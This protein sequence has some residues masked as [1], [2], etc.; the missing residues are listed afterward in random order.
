MRRPVS[1]RNLGAA[2]AAHDLVRRRLALAATVKSALLVEVVAPGSAAEE[3]AAAVRAR[4]RRAI[5]GAAGDDRQAAAIG[6]AVLIGD[7]AGLDPAL[8]AR[9]Q[10]A[11]TF[12]VIAI[13]GGNIALL[14]VLTAWGV[15]WICGRGRLTLAITAVVLVVYAFVVGSGASVLRATGMAVVGLAART[16]DQRAAAINILALTG[17]AL[18]VADPLLAADTG[19]WLT[20]VATAGLVVG[21]GEADPRRPLVAAT[22][23]ALL[24]TSVWA[25]L[26]LLPIVALAF[27]Q[28]T[29]AGVL[30]SAAAIPGMAM[31]QMAAGVAVVGDLGAGWLIAPAGIALRAG[32]G[33]VIESARVV[34][35]LPF[36]SW[37]VPPPHLAVVVA[38]LRGA[39][40]V[41][42][43]ARAGT[44][45]R[46]GAAAA[47]GA[48]RDAGCWRR[49]SRSRR[50]AWWPGAGPT[51]TVTTLDVG[52]GDAIV[53][54]FPNGATMLVDA[55]GRSSGSFDIGARVVGPALRAR[56][57][58]RL[59]YLVVTHAD[60]DHIG[61]AASVVEEFTPAEVWTG[62][63]VAGDAGTAALRRAVDGVG[64]CLAHGAARRPALDRRGRGRRAAS[65]AARLGAPARPQRRLRGAGGDAGA[66]C[67][68][69]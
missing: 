18:L 20:T 25:E 27:E 54:R 56:G 49:G 37:R 29:L 67:G 52:Q 48:V 31:V 11:G 13:S 59:D 57:I 4:A 32:A 12:H 2:D 40:R 69:C 21:L 47:G 28:V 30:L 43:G 6:T 22:G 16:L 64:D 34:E 55:G 42:V 66:A 35:W 51:S 45:E 68:R 44:G 24:L 33:L 38:V 9:L 26:A 8:T 63:P 61:G 10:R 41:G 5:A 60:A 62:V 46:P 39:R 17:A 14:S 3:W 15:G 65:A 1:F 36:L 19:F 50:R 53:V 7:R 58:R 23:P